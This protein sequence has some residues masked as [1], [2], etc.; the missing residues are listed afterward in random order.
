MSEPVYTSGAGAIPPSLI[1]VEDQLFFFCLQDALG[2]PFARWCHKP[3]ETG[4]CQKYREGEAIVCVYVEGWLF[5][6]SLW[7]TV[8]SK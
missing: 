8:A 6:S 5:S 2:F 1:P 3:Q 4:R 7:L